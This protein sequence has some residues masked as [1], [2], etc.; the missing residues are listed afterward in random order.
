M[1]LTTLPLVGNAKL[2]LKKF[3]HEYRGAVSYAQEDPDAPLLKF[4][5]L[6]EWEPVKST[7]MVVC[8]KICQHY[9]SRDNVPDV[10]FVN[11]HVL[12]PILPPAAVDEAITRQRKILIYSESPIMTT[13]LQNVSTASLCRTHIYFVPP[14]RFYNFTMFTVSPLMVA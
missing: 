13:L 11:G 1:F 10:E 6:S 4:T 5:S 2:I 14:R 8:A 12:I 7:K 3:Y 9:L